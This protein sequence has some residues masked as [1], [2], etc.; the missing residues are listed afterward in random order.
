MKTSTQL[1]HEINTAVREKSLPKRLKHGDYIATFE[2]I[3]HA[4]TAHASAK[5]KI[6]R[7]GKEVGTM[8]EG[9]A[10]GW[11][12]PTATTRQ[13]VWGGVIPPGASDP[14]TLE[15]GIAFDIGPHDSHKATLAAFARA[16]D[17]LIAWRK[18][19][20]YPAMGHKR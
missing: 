5:W 11:G 2:G 18:K 7:R 12:R 8:H 19:H 16:A 15:Y 17:R 6:T 9:S 4:G 20:G 1:D 14:R 10:Y 3:T 13:I